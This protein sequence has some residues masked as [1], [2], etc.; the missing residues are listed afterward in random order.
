MFPET[1]AVFDTGRRAMSFVHG[2]NSLQERVIP[3]SPWSTVPRL[4]G[5]TL[6]YGIVAKRGR[7]LVACTARRHRGGDCPTRFFTSA[8]PKE[9]ELGHARAGSARPCRSRG[10]TRGKARTGG[11][12]PCMPRSAKASNCSSGSRDA[13]TR[14]F[15]SSCTTRPLRWT[16]T[17]VCPKPGSRSPRCERPRCRLPLRSLASRHRPH[18]R[19]QP[20][21]CSRFPRGA[22]AKSSSIS[23]PTKHHRGRSHQDAGRR[24][25]LPQVHE[26][27]GRSQEES[28]LRC[29]HGVRR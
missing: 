10:Q 21:G 23:P 20:R 18:L 25:G 3:F 5:S 11:C 2:G 16:S 13:P 24:A 17:R 4:G 6:R 14:A 26:E 28:T 15:S 22:C 9:V 7:P 8:G 27:A 1:T 19:R 12:G 29:A